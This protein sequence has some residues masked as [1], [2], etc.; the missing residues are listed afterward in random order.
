MVTVSFDNHVNNISMALESLLERVLSYTSANLIH[1]I[2][3]ETGVL[4]SL[5]QGGN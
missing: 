4:T 5:S 1:T 2:S 3:P